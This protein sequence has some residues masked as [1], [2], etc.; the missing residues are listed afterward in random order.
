MV[1]HFKNVEKLTFF[2]SLAL[3]IYFND[4]LITH[5]TLSLIWSEL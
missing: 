2:N 5:H 4:I 3:T 1:L